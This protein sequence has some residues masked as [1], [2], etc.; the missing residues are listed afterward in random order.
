MQYL[1]DEGVVARQHLDDADGML[2]A[3]QAEKRASQE[4]LAQAQSEVERVQ[5]SCACNNR[6]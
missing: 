4:R 2:R 1:V 3:R 5:A 6:L